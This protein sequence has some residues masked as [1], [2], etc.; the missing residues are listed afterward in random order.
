MN[1]HPSDKQPRSSPF[2]ATPA[3]SWIGAA[4]MVILILAFYLLREHWGHALGIFPYLL[5]LACPLM[6]IFGH[7]E[8]DHS[9]HGTQKDGKSN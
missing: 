1:T 6:H 4:I 8:H 2:G 9:H 5:L 3:R 7:G